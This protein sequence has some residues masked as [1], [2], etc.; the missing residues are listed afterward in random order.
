MT[1]FSDKLKEV[2]DVGGFL[3]PWFL[4]NNNKSSWL[5]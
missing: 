4:F 1:L 5:S 3:M 2:G